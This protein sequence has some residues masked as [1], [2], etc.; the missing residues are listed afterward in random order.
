[1]PILCTQNWTMLVDKGHDPSSVCHTTP[2]FTSSTTNPASD[3]GCKPA[4]AL[5]RQYTSA[6]PL[7]GRAAATRLLGLFGRIVVHAG[8]AK[9]VLVQALHPRPVRARQAVGAVRQ[10]QLRL[11]A[12]R[13]DKSDCLQVSTR[14]KLYPTVLLILIQSF[15]LIDYL[16][17]PDTRGSV[18][19][20]FNL[21][22]SS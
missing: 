17:G 7:A 12:R 18:V 5:M 20:C 4:L 11:R 13:L 1:M 3:P 21:M 2:K 14:V 8:H 10:S 22:T 16:R 9:R 15:K 19:C 6:Q